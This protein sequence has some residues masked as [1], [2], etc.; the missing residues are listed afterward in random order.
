MAREFKDSLSDILGCILKIE[1]YVEGMH[2]ADFR[3]DEKTQDAV[4]RKLEVIGEAVKNVPKSVQTAYSSVPWK[5][6]AGL[7]DVLIH[8]YF[9]V[10][11]GILEDI[12]YVEMPSLKASMVRIIEDLNESR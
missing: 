7:G 4:I 11:V 8:N 3:E 9:G 2:R 6:M 5:E 1:A 12:V 10:D